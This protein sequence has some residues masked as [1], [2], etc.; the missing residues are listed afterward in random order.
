MACILIPALLGHGSF[1]RGFFGGE[2]WNPFPNIAYGLYQN[3]TI[4]A[5][6]YFLSIPASIYV[7]YQYL[8]FVSCG[9]LIFSILLVLTMYLIIDRPFAALLVINSEVKKALD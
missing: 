8:F 2:I 9:N 1:I 6:V 7:E 5:F 3:V 4:I